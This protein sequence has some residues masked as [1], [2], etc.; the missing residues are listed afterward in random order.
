M[1]DLPGFLSS[2]RVVFVPTSVG[3]GGDT[4]CI[5]PHSWGILGELH[6]DGDWS[7]LVAIDFNGRC[8][9]LIHSLNTVDERGSDPI[10]V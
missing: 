3:V 7:I 1:R 6:T 8:G 10:T 2:N 9:S 5:G 4:L